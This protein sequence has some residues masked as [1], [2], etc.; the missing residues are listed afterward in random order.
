MLSTRG[1]RSCKHESRWLKGPDELVL[2]P[3]LWTVRV[4]L[5]L[6]DGLPEGGD[7][8]QCL[9]PALGVRRLDEPTADDH[10]RPS[11]P[12][13]AVYGTHPPSAF[14]VPQHVHDRKHELP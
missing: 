13:A 1:I 12:T 10:A 9:L 6:L 8:S 14:I 5:A 11:D 4:P 7:D 2:G 3:R